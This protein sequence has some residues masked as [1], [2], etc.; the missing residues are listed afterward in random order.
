MQRPVIFFDLAGTLEVRDP[1]TGR[2]GPWPGADALL[3]DLCADF[4]LHLTTGEAPAFAGPSLEDLGLREFF[5]GVHA[6][7]HGGGKPFGVIAASLGVPLEH[8]L[9][10]GDSARNDTAGDTDRIPSVII[11]HGQ[12]LVAPATLGAV[13]R[14]LWSG[15]SFLG[16]FTEALAAVAG[17]GADGIHAAELHDSQLGG[18]CQLGWWRKTAAS[19]RALVVLAT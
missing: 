10:V 11:V 17:P 16:G 4:D 12:G 9:A 15:A 5:T 7:L 6:G 1:A 19:R 14:G 18:G 2:W 13:V 8:C 3:A